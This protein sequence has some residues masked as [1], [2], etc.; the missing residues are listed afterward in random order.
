MAKAKAKGLAKAMA[1]P[2]ARVRGILRRPAREDGG[3][4]LTPEERWAAGQD[5]QASQLPITLVGTG[6]KVVVSKGH[7][8]LQQCKVAGEVEGVGVKDG[9][10]TLTMR[11]TGTTSE[12]ILKMHGASPQG[13]FRVHKCGADC[14]REEVADTL[15]HGEVMR[16]MRPR[17][18]EEAW[19]HNLEKVVPREEGDELEMLR[20]R[21]RRL[22]PATPGA[23]EDEKDTK[24]DKKEAKEKE[25]KRAKKEKKAKKKERNAGGDKEAQTSDSTIVARMDGGRCEGCRKEGSIGPVQGTGL[26]PKE[27]TRRKVVKAAR[28]HLRKKG[29]RKSSSGS[30]DSTSSSSSTG[31]A[32][33]SESVFQQAS[34]V[35][36][37]SE[38]FPGALASQGLSQMRSALLSGLGEDDQPGVLKPC[39]LQYFRQHLQKSS[40]GAAKEQCG[41]SASRA[42]DHCSNR[43]LAVD[44]KSCFSDGPSTTTFQELRSCDQWDPLVS[45]PETRAPSP[46]GGV[47]GH[48]CLRWMPL[49]RTSMPSPG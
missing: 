18:G 6:E 35:R 14:N 3:E 28:R 34:K 9:E 39:A 48:R 44:R 47:S 46:G 21:E 40:A 11:L 22:A 12:G 36:R 7:Y 37:V 15:V 19:A 32:M 31:P 45:C 23:Q 26:D 13:I 16:Q 33:D 25:K 8:Y 4:G 43:R 20:M 41:S 17:D 1:R 49:R 10:V 42:P 29:D 38:R 24:K 27:R 2:A 5:V 30:G